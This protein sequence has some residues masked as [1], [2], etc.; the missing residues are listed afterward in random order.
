MQ[1]RGHLSISRKTAV[2]MFSKVRGCT[3]LRVTLEVFQ[4]L[5]LTLEK[6]L[7]MYQLCH[8]S[9]RELE[10]HKGM[11]R[12][13]P[14]V[15]AKGEKCHMLPAGPALYR[16]PSSPQ[17]GRPRCPQSPHL[18]LTLLCISAPRNQHASKK[19]TPD[20]C[21]SSVLISQVQVMR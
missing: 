17:P 9:V 20:F 10:Q 5:K 3:S 4:M 18:Q 14:S 16:Q 15:C 6:L 21:P 7:K 12:R 1:T 8:R 19:H 13:E 2:L 11:M